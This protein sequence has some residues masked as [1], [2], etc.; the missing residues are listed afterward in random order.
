M[1]LVGKCSQLTR[2]RWF[3]FGS[4]YFCKKVTHFFYKQC[5]FEQ[6][7]AEIGKKN[8]AKK[9][10]SSRPE[11]FIGKG[12]LKICSKLTGEHPCRSAIPITSKLLC[13]CKQHPEAE[14]LLF[15]NYSVSSSMLPSKTNVRCSTKCAKNKCL[16]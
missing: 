14:R 9:H 6:H 7:Q 15:G 2:N 5:L 11:R 10:R 8:Q 1:T 13:F 12:V 3:L 4:S 16:F